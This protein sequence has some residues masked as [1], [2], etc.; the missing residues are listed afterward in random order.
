MAS[1]N[2]DLLVIYAFNFIGI[3]Y[4]WGGNNPLEGMDC[5]GFLCEVL[6]SQGLV[7]EDH[8]AQS[9]YDL[10]INIGVEKSIEKG[11]LLFF[12]NSKYSITHC[13]IAVNPNLMLEAGG[14]GADTINKEMAIKRNA[15]IRL[16]PMKFRKDLI[17]S[18]TLQE[19]LQ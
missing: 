19:Y 15:F 12:G 8:S 18:I 7:K 6:R 10:F 17:S 9:L 11:S 14:G 16:R 5:S 4:K 3:N 1:I 13:S 2:A